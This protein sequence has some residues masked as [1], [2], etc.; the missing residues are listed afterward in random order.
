M[1]LLSDTISQVRRGD[2][3]PRVANAVGYLSGIALKA[4]EQ[5]ELNDRLSRLE[6]TVDQ[7]RENRSTRYRQSA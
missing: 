3:D 1:A 6:K 5:G 7:A 4:R 2:I